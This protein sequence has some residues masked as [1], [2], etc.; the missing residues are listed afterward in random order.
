M[1]RAYESMQG[2]CIKSMIAP[3]DVPFCCKVNETKLAWH[4]AALETCAVVLETCADVRKMKLGK[5]GGMF[6]KSSHDEV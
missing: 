6:D 2:M 3:F 1:G 5:P 4:F